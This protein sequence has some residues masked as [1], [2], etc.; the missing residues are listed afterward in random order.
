MQGQ[1]RPTDLQWSLHTHKSTKLKI[2][3]LFYLVRHED[4]QLFA[5]S[6]GQT[7]PFIWIQAE[8]LGL[9]P[10]GRP[11]RNDQSNLPSCFF[12]CRV[13]YVGI[14]LKKKKPL[15]DRCT[16]S[17]STDCELWPAYGG[18]SL[19]LKICYLLSR[20]PPATPESPEHWPA[21]RTWLVPDPANTGSRTS[22]CHR[23]NL[24]INLEWCF[25]NS[26]RS[27]SCLNLIWITWSPGLISKT[28]TESRRITW[29]RV[30]NVRRTR[31]FWNLTEENRAWHVIPA[32][33]R[34]HWTPALWSD[35]MRLN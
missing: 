23:K 34:N 18:G 8:S 27:Q 28:E 12:S 29:C 31:V 7:D 15:L 2:S 3:S 6:S 17:C 1:T 26:R 21:P 30:R 25:M 22:V 9:I 13:H 4:L 5:A 10:A 11:Q 33:E 16:F 20:C 35:D 32:S 24:R 19:I 14:A